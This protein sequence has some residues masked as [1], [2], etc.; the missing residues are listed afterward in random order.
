MLNISSILVSLFVVE[1]VMAVILIS[2]LFAK[3]KMNGLKEM[4]AATT[5]GSVGS[6]LGSYGTQSGSFEFTYIALFFFMFSVA[7]ASRSMA[8]LQNRVPRYWL[9]ASAL[10]MSAGFGFW[11]IVVNDNLG[12]AVIGQALMYALICGFTSWDLM[13]EKR[14]GLSL[15]CKALGV[16]FGCFAVVQFLRAVLRPVFMVVGDL[17]SQIGVLDFVS[18][19]AGMAVAIGWSLGLLWTSYR[20]SEV[21]LQAAYRELEHFANAAAHDLKSPLGA[22]I[23]NLEAAKYMAPDRTTE[24]VS[25]YIENAH[26][27]ALRLNKFIGDMLEDARNAQ[28]NPEIG[29]V[30]TQA[31][32]KEAIARLEAQIAASNAEIRLEE[33]LPVRASQTQLIRVFQNLF[34]N[35]IKYKAEDRNPLIEVVSTS[36]GRNVQVDIKDNGIGMSEEDLAQVFNYFGRS[37]TGSSISGHGIGLSECKRIIESLGGILVV[38]ST[39]NEGSC[40]SFRLPQA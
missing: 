14:L 31:C 17:S 16:M 27:G 39:E 34:D 38:N 30:D 6:V 13:A 9:E 5:A 10:A 32:A 40:F 21:Q 4:A 22:V 15:G 26:E 28:L 12:P 24:D 8:R 19:F 1:I 35:A 36:K 7:S 3:M 11:F 29:S 23:G 37:E 25:H 18:A 20:N 2:F 33:L